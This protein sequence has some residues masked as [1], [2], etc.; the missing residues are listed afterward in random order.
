MTMPEQQVLG[1]QRGIW[2]DERWLQ[3][4]GLGSHLRVIVQPGEIRILAAPDEVEQPET[5]NDVWSEEAIEA[6]RS[7]GRD[8]QP[9]QLKNTSTN[10]DQYL[11]G[12]N[13]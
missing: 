6:W 10:H 11:Y 2:I 8:A 13:E 5:A 9:G 3:D 12:K 7:L 4:A 1:V